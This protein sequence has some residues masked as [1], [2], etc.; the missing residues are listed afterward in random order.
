M[1]V[2]I[3]T[4]ILPLKCVKGK[5]AVMFVRE[6]GGNTTCILK[7]WHCHYLLPLPLKFSTILPIENGLQQVHSNVMPLI[8]VF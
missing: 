8:A 2:N 1:E 6:D 5:L 4:V 7:P 3:A